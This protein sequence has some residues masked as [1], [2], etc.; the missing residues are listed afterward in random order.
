M[1][2]K[3]SRQGSIEVLLKIETMCEPLW[4]YAPGVTQFG[5]SLSRNPEDWDEARSHADLID[6]PQTI[7]DV[8]ALAKQ[9]RQGD[10]ERDDTEIFTNM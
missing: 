2:K 7:A 9:A 6:L 5:D 3:I 8:F 10:S 4:Q 1:M